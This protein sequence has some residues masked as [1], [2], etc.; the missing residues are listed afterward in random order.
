MRISKRGF[1]F[2]FLFIVLSSRFLLS[3]TKPDLYYKE[4]SNGGTV[5][6]EKDR[7]PFGDAQFLCDNMQANDPQKIKEM[8]AV[9]R[10]YVKNTENFVAEIKENDFMVDF[11]DSFESAWNNIKAQ[12]AE[13]PVGTE[14]SPKGVG[15]LAPEKLIPALALLIIEHAREELAISFFDNWKKKLS[16]GDSSKIG[17]LFPN[18]RKYLLGADPLNYKLFLTQLRN[19]FQEDLKS[20]DDNIIQYLR[21]KKTSLGFS[22]TQQEMDAYNL[23]I[24][25]LDFMKYLREKNHPSLFLNKL[26]SLQEIK[27]QNNPS[28]KNPLLLLSFFSNSMA[29]HEKS[30]G[31]IKGREFVDA[32]KKSPIFIGLFIGLVV[33]KDRMEDSILE[34]IS[35]Q[36]RESSESISLESV[37]LKYHKDLETIQN[38]AQDFLVVSDRIADLIDMKPSSP[39][40]FLSYAQETIK[41]FDFICSLAINNYGSQLSVD[42]CNRIE[43]FQQQTLKRIDTGLNITRKLY[44]KNY[45]V[46]F[47]NALELLL[48]LFP[49]SSKASNKWIGQINDGIHKY[50]TFM[51]AIINAEDSKKVKEILDGVVLP[52]GSYRLKRTR[53][54]SISL[55]S[56]LGLYGFKEKSYDIN[57]SSTEKS[58]LKSSLSAPIGIAFNKGSDGYSFSIFISMI[59]IGAVAEFR[60]TDTEKGLSE[61][62]WKNVLAPGLFLV[63]GF[64]NSPLSLGFGWQLS[65][66]LRKINADGTPEFK[67]SS[68]RVGLMLVVDIP[69]IHFK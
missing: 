23:A 2:L 28:I 7:Y 51:V 52:V 16:E 45:S 29:N 55:N 49:E 22:A 58:H 36:L 25:L 13:T 1:L 39:E 60:T 42:D 30:G 5:F 12:A 18:T 3:N 53:P 34:N 8:A 40:A 14:V 56:Y 31:W 38:L 65:P 21:N 64:K 69:L 59:D 19:I 15:L 17:Y 4:T 48:Q 66:E 43:T 50:G 33:Q 24:I 9:L 63:F 67:K 26:G 6:I 61:I 54:F 62:E 20:M 46:A 35:I 27:E 37:I 47:A 57:E 68:W 11:M 10:K 41:L 32:C 44:E